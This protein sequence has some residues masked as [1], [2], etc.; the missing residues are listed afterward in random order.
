MN[1]AVLKHLIELDLLLLGIRFTT[2]DRRTY[3]KQIGT[4]IYG[5]NCEF[6]DTRIYYTCVCFSEP[7][8][9]GVNKKKMNKLASTSSLLSIR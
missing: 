4:R 2:V 3:V 9:L 5:F 8:Q 1:E 6:V 7:V